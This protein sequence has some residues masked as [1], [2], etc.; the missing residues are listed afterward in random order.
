MIAMS[1][2]AKVSNH[3]QL[4]TVLK[5]FHI[6]VLKEANARNIKKHLFIHSNE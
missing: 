1:V 5:K 6:Q 4:Q 2:S 3:I